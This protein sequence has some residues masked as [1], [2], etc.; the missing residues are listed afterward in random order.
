[1]ATQWYA[2]SDAQQWTE[3]ESVVRLSART[4]AHVVTG[5]PSFASRERLRVGI[6]QRLPQALRLSIDYGRLPA[7]QTS[8]RSAGDR[9]R[10]LVMV[11]RNWTL[12][13]PAAGGD[14]E[15]TI[16][17]DSGAP[18]AGAAIA[19][20]RYLTSSGQDG[21]YRFP[22]VPPGTHTL[23]VVGEHLPAAY[24]VA[25]EP[26][27][28]P[29]ADGRTTHV[30]VAVVTL[31]A[32][33]GRVF[34]DRNGDGDVDGGEGVSGVVVRLQAAG[35]ATLTS[36]DGA[37]AFYNLDPGR[38]EVWIDRE[39]LSPALEI[40]SAPRVVDLQP[41]RPANAVDFLLSPHDKPILLKELP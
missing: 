28:V 33:R 10:L 17:D 20:G 8:S 2:G 38:Y 6:E 25:G 5:F 24:G 36:I 34:V 19:L 7:F 30:D 15:G 22:H 35:A 26:R 21:R 27:A 11:R 4:S 37:F 13:T 41:D 18:V 12:R 1:V 9:S 23:E 16:R 31:R 40:V 32:I 29:V 14:V 39:R 3:L